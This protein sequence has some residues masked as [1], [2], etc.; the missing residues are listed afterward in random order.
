VAAARGGPL[1]Y[2]DEFNLAFRPL[3]KFV[4]QV[5]RVREACE[6]RGRDP[7]TLTYSCALVACIG[8]NEAEIS[9]RAAAI[10]RDVDE[11]RANGLAGTPDEALE[12]LAAWKDAGA[13][14]IYLQVLDLTDLEHVAL[15]GSRF[16][17]AI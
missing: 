3:E 13:E 11:L 4:D 14:R 15:M 8:E 12:R 9:R 17:G 10:G 16:V 7:E 5:H 2:A 1:V 6:Q